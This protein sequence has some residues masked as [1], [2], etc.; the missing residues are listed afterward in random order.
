MCPELCSLYGCYCADGPASACTGDIWTVWWPR[1][2]VRRICCVWRPS[3]KCTRIFRV[4]R[5]PLASTEGR[6]RFSPRGTHINRWCHCPHGIYLTCFSSRLRQEK[7]KLN[8]GLIRP[9]HMS[10]YLSQRLQKL[11]EIPDLASL[12]NLRSLIHTTSP[13]AIPLLC[14]RQSMP[15]QDG[16]FSKHASHENFYLSTGIVFFIHFEPA[17][18]FLVWLYSFLMNYIFRRDFEWHF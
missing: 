13:R 12:F 9:N 3:G 15:Y 11:S 8:T 18:Y 14:L 10:L 17:R 16:N 6:C 2:I 4:I 5:I 1:A 7:I